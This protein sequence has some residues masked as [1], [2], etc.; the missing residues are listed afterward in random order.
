MEEGV[1]A[2]KL[3]D[4][5]SAA[6]DAVKAAFD[7]DSIQYELAMM[8]IDMAEKQGA[9]EEGELDESAGMVYCK[10]RRAPGGYQRRPP[11]PPGYDTQQ[12]AAKKTGPAWQPKWH[13]GKY[14]E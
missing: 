2:A 14:E 1:P 5:A 7:P 10:D 6:R 11:C 8:V 9:P 4:G 12:I 3:A 13:G